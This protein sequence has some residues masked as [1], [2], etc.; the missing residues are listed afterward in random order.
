[1]SLFEEERIYLKA[2]LIELLETLKK[3]R[4]EL[5]LQAHLAKAELKDEIN[6]L[7]QKFKELQGKRGLL[8]DEISQTSEEAMKAI[9]SL[10]NE[11][12]TGYQRLK[13]LIKD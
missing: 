10:G 4:D 13:K 8:K 1:M 9:K 12:H 7:E 6:E 5:H 2:E 11:L 3:Q